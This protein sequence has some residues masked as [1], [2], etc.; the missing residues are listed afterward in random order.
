[1]Y[2]TYEISINYDNKIM[3]IPKLTKKND[4]SIIIKTPFIFGMFHTD[5]N[6]NLEHQFSAVLIEEEDCCF[7]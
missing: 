1:M 6:E 3:G 2:E 7:H 4:N 5:I